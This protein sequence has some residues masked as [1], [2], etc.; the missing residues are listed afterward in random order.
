MKKDKIKNIVKS[1]IAPVI[2]LLIIVAGILVI[3]FWDNPVE[4]VEI[5]KVNAYDGVE[6]EIV[7]ENDKLKFVMDSTTTQ[8]SLLVKDTGKV[9]YSNPLDADEDKI[10]LPS[11]KEK[12]K[13]TLVLT[14]STINGVNTVYSN[15]TYSIVNGI[16][17]IEVNDDSIKVYY[18]IGD[19]DKEYVIPSVI[20]EADMDELLSNMNKSDAVTVSEYYKKY[21]IEK[22]GKRDDKE[23]LL[24][25]Y[26]I[27]E[28][29]VI[30]ILR[31]TTKDNLKQKFEVFFADAGY[32]YEAYLADKA[33]DGSVKTSEKPVFNVNITYKLDGGDFIVEVPMDEMEYK[34]DYPILYL[35]V[36]PYLG[37]GGEN[38]EGYM[39]VP[40]GGGSIIRFNNGKL[41]Q[42]SYY[43]NMYGWDMG[44]G[45]DSIVHETKTCFNVFGMAHEEDSFICMLEEGVPYAY[46]SADIS[47]RN[48]AYNYANASYSI[49]HREQY[50]VAD[51]YNGE[52]YVYEENIPKGNIVQR[53]QFINSASYVDMAQTY[54][55][56][57]LNQ[58]GGLLTLND[59][60]STPT[61]IEL[62]G[63]V[64]K[65]KQIFGIPVSRPLELTTYKD[66][67]SILQTLKADG[68]DNIS[69]K[70]SGWMNGGIKQRMLS[71]VHLI[72]ELGSKK[73]FKAL[74]DYTNNNGINLYLDGTTNYAYDSNLFDGFLAFRD[75]ARLV[76]RENVEILEFST[77][78]YGEEDY[79]D[80]YYL[81]R[82]RVSQ[83][84]LENLA[85]GA[86]QYQSYG[87]S[88]RE[89]GNELPADYDKNNKV[90]RQKVMDLE[91]E[92]LKELDASGMGIMINA[93]NN[94]AIPYSD[95]VTNMDFAGSP[96][97]I[98]D[99]TVP[100]YQMALH[101]YVNYAGKALNLS[102][103]Y[104]EELLR[105][106]EYGAG[107]YFVFMEEDATVLQNTYYTHYYGA[108]FN[109]WYDKM[110]EIYTRY[111]KD[112]GSTYNQQMVSH[113]NLEAKVT[114]T[115]YEDG[116][117]VYVNYSF[118]DYVTENG[119]KVP[120]RD[121]IAVR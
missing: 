19:L 49:L 102:K 104:Q 63:A 33:L 12:L 77:I 50:D 117:N 47:G 27:L 21:D 54:R 114:C 56:Y 88:L 10:A 83:K 87:I 11:D 52:M 78:W 113:E 16:Y 120:A 53:Y 118:K 13:S 20:T 109:A 6:E 86:K 64:D 25:S 71:D 94:Y 57:L 40:E 89:I 8:F 43:A 108:D 121:Y 32:T 58:S 34:E 80:S 67:L 48:N 82:P 95:F 15:Y 44:Q 96:Y 85:N 116:T 92:K 22:L 73:D 7:M 65:V 75:A 61:A 26:P 46:I 115:T 30:Y 98:I 5:I 105:S 103:D 111:D 18:S 97:T 39:L 29:D 107:L 69:V 28:S 93:G 51:K 41:S 119:I 1:L 106:A 79:K 76:S 37:A 100:F 60:A 99:E 110:S 4:P 17:D 101:G 36:L 72:R 90:S 70:L 14:Y 62:V 84:M 59:D 3:T 23:A 31:D 2:V 9:W 112:L 66:S 91:V 24:A 74:I 81:L 45:R 42:N 35:N 68:M 38:D 55:E